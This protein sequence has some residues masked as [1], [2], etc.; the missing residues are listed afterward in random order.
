MKRFISLLLV[1]LIG[2]FSAAQPSVLP[3][4]PRFDAPTTLITQLE[5][6]DL[7]IMLDSLARSV[8]LTPITDTVPSTTINYR[9]DEAKPFRQIWSIILTQYD[10]DFALLDND[11]VIIGTPEAIASF[12]HQEVLVSL[13]EDTV[14]RFYRVNNESKDVA[15]LVEQ[16]VRGTTVSALEGV[17]SISVVGTEVQQLEVQAI[18]D[19]FDTTILQEPLVQRIY[20]LSHASAESLAEVLQ[21]SGITSRQLDGNAEDA[22]TPEA[23]FTVVADIRTNSLIVTAS[24][25]VQARIAELVPPLDVPQQQINVQVR[26]QEISKRA[27]EDLGINLKAGLGNFAASVLDGGLKFVFDAQRALSGLNIGAVLDTL[28][29]Q[30]LARRVDDSTL[31]VLNNGTGSIQSGGTIFISLPG[32]GEN[33][34]RTIEYGVIIEVTPRITNDGRIIM[35]VSAKL[36][37]PV[38]TT[39]NPQF[40]ELSTRRV[41]STITIEEG[42]T[43]LLGGLFQNQ[44]TSSVDRVPV[45]GSIPIIGS[46]FS[47]TT[48]ELIDT[49]LLL[50]VT[51][52]ILD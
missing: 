47:Q 51:A 19:Q 15:A 26:I 3:D 6:E 43:I 16:A 12:T 37:Q 41:V 36:D 27:A 24:A 7:R 34:E 38:S 25:A 35:E 52:D 33:I 10:L 22:R 44:L 46:L 5:G 28:E 32:A 1:L 21:A 50:I 9:I 48:N 11:V 17:K 30:R 39:E 18:L 2:V 31:T 29:T 23:E 49:E 8:G 4:D 14:Q 42:Q 40:L 20:T 45:L 13:P